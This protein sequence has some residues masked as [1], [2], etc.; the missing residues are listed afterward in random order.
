MK[1][2]HKILLINPPF[3][4]FY[5]THQRQIPL[6]LKYLQAS[7]EKAGYETSLL[8]CLAENHQRIIP[9]P[10]DLNYLQQYYLPNDLSPFKLFTHYR[11][12]GIQSN[13]I[14]NKIKK[15][16]PDL[17]GISINFTPYWETAIEIAR[18]CKSLCPRVP[19]VAGGHHATVAPES[20]LGSK[21]IDF[22]VLG[23][24]EKR[25]LQLIKI[26]AAR[27][28]DQLAKMEGIAFISLDEIKINQPQNAIQNLDD[29]PWPK[30]DG[31]IAM[32]LTSRGCPKQCNFCSVANVMGKK[33]RFRTIASVIAEM[34]ACWHNGITKFDFEDDN[35]TFD[36]QRALQLFTEITKRFA[37]KN[38][39]LSAQNGLMA[40]SLDEELIRV[41]KVAGFE[42]LNVPLVSS[43]Q[44]VQKKILRYQSQEQFLKIID[45]AEKYE[46]KVI[47][48][49]ILGL[50]EEAIDH[51]LEDILF[52]TGLPV[53]IGPS[54]FYP[55]P[56]SVTYQNCVRNKFITGVDFVHYRS[57]AMAVQTNNFSR[58]D[59]ITLFRLVRLVN[60]LK[61][62]PAWIEN[63]LFQARP[64][65]STQANSLIFD[66]KLNQE[67]IG[68]L[69]IDELAQHKNFWGL[70][71]K[72]RS[73]DSYHYQWIDYHCSQY[74]VNKFFE[75]LAKIEICN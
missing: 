75:K 3:E 30:S 25:L 6:G 2:I 37:G 61:R 20:I 57:T 28:L 55:P 46:L 36:R 17:I 15:A 65:T 7:L 34:E 58:R 10:E 21:I 50:P 16:Q 14:A 48:Y 39:I 23:E 29:L 19:I 51:V 68:K 32:I 71:L 38:L 47:A 31:A 63:I 74:L 8:D 41:M 44:Q 54:L 45:W 43:S 70:S 5:Q 72:K 11:H 35:L 52:L 62:K 13:E 1:T 4:D 59:I 60:Y 56:G 12:F 73:N 64:I 24:G 67:E 33:I 53:I 40:D 69:I 42:W 9:F 27:D 18:L 66:H 26:L 22:V 49:L